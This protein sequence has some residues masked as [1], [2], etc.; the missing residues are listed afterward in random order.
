MAAGLL[1]STANK[2]AYGRKP[3]DYRCAHIVELSDDFDWAC[4]IARNFFCDH[5]DAV[6]LER[7]AQSSYKPMAQLTSRL[8]AEER[9]H[10]DHSD[11]WIQRLGKG[12]DDARRRLQ[13]ALD[14]LSSLATALFE[15]TGGHDRL[16]AAG[17]Y[18]KVQP[19]W[20]HRWL[21][22]IESVAGDAG[23]RLKLKPIASDYIGGRQGKHSADFATLLDELTEVYRLEPEAAW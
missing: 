10:V 14:K 23:L 22:D 12:G 9:I 17:V 5:F 20:F 1:G 2:L 16:E 19:E 8:L 3:E 6:R 15:P 11:L 4:A 13:L 21:T 18:P 7:L